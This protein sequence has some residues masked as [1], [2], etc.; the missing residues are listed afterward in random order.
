MSALIWCTFPDKKAARYVADILLDEGL[1]A[2]ANIIDGMISLFVWDGERGED[3]ETGVLFKT[4]SER[5]NA[6]VS[7]IE[8]LHPYKTPAILGWKCDVVTDATRG[9]LAQPKKRAE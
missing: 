5:L 2:C 9:W 3:R 6:A 7:R 8:V 1:V 4:N